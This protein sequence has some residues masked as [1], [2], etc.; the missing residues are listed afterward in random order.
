VRATRSTA[1]GCTRSFHVG[2]GQRPNTRSRT[3][4]PSATCLL[5]SIPQIVL[6]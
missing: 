2:R 3:P 4:P 1:R 6:L 5:P